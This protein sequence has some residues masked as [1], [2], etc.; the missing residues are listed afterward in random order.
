MFRLSLPRPLLLALLAVASAGCAS[1]HVPAH[2]PDDSPAS[3]RA[4]EARP[5]RVTQAIDATADAPRTA[6]QAP[7]VDPHEGHHGHH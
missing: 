5:A 3:S 4:P 1:R 7:A 6:Q 2:F